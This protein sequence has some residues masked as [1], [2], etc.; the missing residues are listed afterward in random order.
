MTLIG[1]WTRDRIG[2]DAGSTLTGVG[3]RAGITVVTRSAVRLGRIRTD[4]RAWIARPCVVTLVA[5]GAGLWSSGACS[6]ATNIARRTEIAV[7]AG[8]AVRLG[9]IRTHACARITRAGVMT[10]IGCRA[11]NRIGARANSR[12]TAISLRASVPIVACGA[13]RFRWIRTDSG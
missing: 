1:R 9:R 11:S 6:I 8:S 7:V 10:L 4:A 2:A 5:G 3:L 12:L 13:V